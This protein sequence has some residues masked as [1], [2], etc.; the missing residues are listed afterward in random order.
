MSKDYLGS[1]V[2]PP[3]NSQFPAL[4]AAFT[5]R[6]GI[7]ALAAFSKPL[8][9]RIRKKPILTLNESEVLM[10]N[11]TIASVLFVYNGDNDAFLRFLQTLVHDYINST[12]IPTAELSG[13]LAI[14]PGKGADN[15]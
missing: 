13:Q 14:F 5:G 10:T 15:D 7:V 11:P 3:K 4:C 1:I 6:V 2:H 8:K 9:G 12:I